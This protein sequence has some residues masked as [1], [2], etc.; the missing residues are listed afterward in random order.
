MAGF[1]ITGTDTGVGKTFATVALM[2]FL[3]SRGLSVVGM[4]PVATGCFLRGGE[5]LNEDALQL[6]ENSSLTVD[7]G[8][9]NIYAFEPPASPHLA[10]RRAGIVVRLDAI[11]EQCR[12]LERLADC[13]LVEGVGGFEVPLNDEDRVSDLAIALGLPVLLVVGM[14][15]GCLNHA[16]LTQLAMA[17]RGVDFAGWIA[18]C[19]EEDFSFLEDN[20]HTLRTALNVPCLGTIPHAVQ[21]RKCFSESSGGGDVFSRMGEEI[22]RRLPV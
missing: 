21:G 17:R 4:K 12:A 7:Y 11:V 13:V 19:I 3:K 6:Q 22:L 2:Q 16:L 9:L 18:N 10:A 1:F 14:R 15:L 8:K 20:L 5:L